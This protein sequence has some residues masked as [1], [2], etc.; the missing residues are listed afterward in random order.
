MRRAILA[1]LVVVTAASGVGCRRLF[2]RKHTPHVYTPYTVYPTSV[3]TAVP[4]IA[5]T[6][7]TTPDAGPGYDPSKSASFA[8]HTTAC[9]EGRGAAVQCNLVGI[10][11]EEGY[12]TPIDF[13]SAGKY[14]RLA[15][16]GKLP[17]GCANLGA[18]YDDGKGFAEDK[19]KAD[20]IYA[21]ACTDGSARGCNHLGLHHLYAQGG[22]AIDNVKAADYFQKG[23]D[24]HDPYS[25]TNLGYMYWRGLGVKKDLPK[26]V[27]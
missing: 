5:A 3:P 23:C 11:Y 21:K 4:T 19:V 18:L 24:K 2:H 13:L 17:D 6:G 15:C 9:D 7:S 14:Y 22:H 12:G 16:D 27:G 26:M 1:G 20:G 10:D 8:S 25:C